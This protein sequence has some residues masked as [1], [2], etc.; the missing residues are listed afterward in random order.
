MAKVMARVSL[1]VE[2]D[3]VGL[4]GGRGMGK[5]RIVGKRVLKTRSR[6]NRLSSPGPIK[7]P[8]Y[9]SARRFTGD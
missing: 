8:R 3:E 6:S 4:K 1:S 5:G 7:T 2:E 9:E